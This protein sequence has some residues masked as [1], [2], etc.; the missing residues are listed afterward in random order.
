MREGDVEDLPLPTVGQTVTL[1][2]ELRKFV[3]ADLATDTDVAWDNDQ[4]KEI[5]AT[6]QESYV[7]VASDITPPLDATPGAE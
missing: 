2:G 4:V 5:E 7:F 1:Q 3:V 6:Y